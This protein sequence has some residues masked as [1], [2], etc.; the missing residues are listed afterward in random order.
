MVKAVVTL[1]FLVSLF[2]FL[3]VA[4]PANADM[5]GHGGMVRALDV[6]NDGRQVLSGSFDFTARLWDFAEQKEI[7]VLDDHE[8][9][10][11]SVKFIGA[12][13]ALTASDDKTAIVWDLKT[14]KPI[15]RLEGHEHKVMGLAVSND[16]KHAATGSWDRTV[17]LWDLNQGKA[18]Q[19]FRHSSAVNTVVFTESGKTIAA[20]GHD[21]KIWVWD[22]GSGR[23][24]GVLEG[25]ELGITGLSASPDGKRL[26]SSSIDKTLRLWDLKTMTEVKVYKEHEA[27]VYTVAF[28]PDGKTALSAGRE[29][30]LV[31]WNLTD[32]NLLRVIRAIRARKTIIW[33][34]AFSP[35]GRFVLTASS[36]DLIR[37]WHLESGDRIGLAAEGDNE[38]KPWLDS[39]HPGA[40]VYK[41]CARCH[42]LSADGKGRS[43]PH[44]AGLFGRAAGSVEGYNYSSALTGVDFRWNKKTLYDLF[45]QGPAKYLPGTKM[46]MQLV[47]DPKQ[48]TQLVEYLKELTVEKGRD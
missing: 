2:V 15:Q 48:L 32:G 9:P 35:D 41:K 25:H 33:S 13:R 20:G 34:A 6:S 24:K 8:G 4:G 16:A 30:T 1:S 10:V 3:G 11:T 21:G 44:F 42:S 28:S 23:S 36:D 45:D 38:P 19:V 12:D 26:L 47:S 17:R 29:G 7:G 14:F 5:S 22:I 27:P 18:I 31:Q 40:Q 37:V 43:G 39:D 46:P